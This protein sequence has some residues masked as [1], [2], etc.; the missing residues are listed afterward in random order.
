MMSKIDCMYNATD[1][2]SQVIS[3][4]I[5]PRVLSPFRVGGIAYFND[6]DSYAGWSFFI[7]IILV[8]PPKPDRL[9]DRDQR[10]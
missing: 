9:K 3:Y 7:S 5:S 10:K 2:C 1:H 4:F 6:P 8:G